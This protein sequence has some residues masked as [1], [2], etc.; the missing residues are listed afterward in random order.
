MALTCGL[1]AG[2]GLAVTPA[3]EP[4][5]YFRNDWNV[6]GLPD[7]ERGTRVTPDNRLEL[8]DAAVEIRIGRGLWP[9]G[10]RPVK[11]LRAG[12]L[13]VVLLS[14]ADGA[15]RYDVELWATPLPNVADWARAFAGPS[16]GENYLNWIRVAATNTGGEDAAARIR[17]SSGRPAADGEVDRMLAPGTSTALTVRVPFAPVADASLFAGADP[18]LW[19]ARTVEHWTGVFAA[20]ARIEVPCRKATEALL[21]AHVCQLIAADHGEVHGGEG[22][23]DEFYIR[24]GAYQVLELAEA[25]LADAAARAVALYLSRQR[26]D[27]RFESQAGQLDANGQAVWVL[28][29]HHRM[30]GDRAGLESVYP[31]LRRAADWTIA[32]RRAAPAD[33]PFAG[34]LPAALADGEYLWGGEHHITG[35]DLWNLRGL[36]CTADAARE[37]G[38]LDEAA[39]LSREAELYRAAIDAAWTRTGCAHFPPSWEGAGTPWG[40]TETLWPTAIFDR[41]D[42]RVA[43]LSRHVRQEFRGGFVE[44]TIRWHGHR[45]AIHP[46]LGAYTTM[47][48]LARGRHEEVVADFHGYLLHSTAAH[49][50]PEGI[51]PER[52]EAWGDTIPHGTGA[53]NY[54]ILLRHM[55]LHE[56]G[57][58]LHL[59]AAVPDG[60]LAEGREIRV[61]RAPTHFGRL[62]F[63]VRG[64]AAGVRIA[65]APPERR[66]PA[67]IVLHLPASRPLL[68]VLPGVEVVTRAPQVERW[69]FPTT[70]ARY[71]ASGPPPRVPAPDAPSLT[72][73]RPATCSS[74]L[75]AFPAELA[76]DGFAADTDCYWAT[77][78]DAGHDPRPW[79]R[80]DL[81]EPVVVGRVVVVAYYG[82]ERS[83]GFVVETS[84]DGKS[85][86]L[87]AEQRAGE[88][89]STR[90]GYGFRFAARPARHIRV[91]QT[92]NSAN[93]GRHLVEVMAFPE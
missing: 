85:W 47:A 39:E 24:D 90:A 61:E 66:P 76:N 89:L 3:D 9:L 20:A 64:T 28:W 43:A 49:A 7:Y 2:G 86:E 16:E 75:S 93:T 14:A 22:F 4:F 37:L 62:G 19:L 25:G 68:D 34:L 18:D 69:D 13:P 38:R 54:A 26:P 8:A 59:L 80:V 83:Y 48:D 41:D 82:D 56:E 45:S 84:L 79:W 87:V 31:R 51:Y 46:Y 91:T 65:F 29:Q 12:W 32:A 70:V 15:V 55:L 6:L 67:R 23:Y 5:D 81:E 71:E 40:N 78:V 58:E 1:I 63:T 11:T 33:S 57:E 72:T 44:G 17:V 10:P 42:P 60:W 52:R 30:T 36:L 88:E 73:G 77:D 35:Y 50:F 74:A 21:A 53:A 27:G 92:A